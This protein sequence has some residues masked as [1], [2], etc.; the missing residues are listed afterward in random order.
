MVYIN[1]SKKKN[2]GDKIRKILE[3]SR[4]VSAKLAENNTWM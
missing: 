3:N 1:E 4:T 2:V